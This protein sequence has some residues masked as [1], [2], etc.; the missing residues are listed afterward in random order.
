MFKIHSVKLFEDVQGSAEFKALSTESRKALELLHKG[1]RAC[2]STEAQGILING[3]KAYVSNFWFESEISVADGFDPIKDFDSRFYG[4]VGARKT[5]TVTF[6][7]FAEGSRSEVSHMMSASNA[8]ISAPVAPV[9]PVKDDKKAA[10]LAPEV[11]ETIKKVFPGKAVEEHV[12]ASQSRSTPK[13][14][15]GKK[16]KPTINKK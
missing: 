1:L 16:T 3:K 8:L 13:G 2:A 14:K 6:F 15:G 10:P 5:D 9:A 12:S 11:L 7:I 4:Y